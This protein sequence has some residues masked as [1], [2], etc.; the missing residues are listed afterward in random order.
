MQ[1]TRDLLTTPRRPLDIE[2]YIDIVRR[3]K[4]WLIGPTFAALVISVVLAFLW[5]DSYI[6]LAT[7]QVVPPQVPDR[8]VPT[9]VNLEMSQRINTMAGQILN[10]DTLTNI[11][12][13]YGLYKKEISRR[14]MEDVIEDMRNKYVKISPVLRVHGTGAR[15]GSVSA[16]SIA[17]EYENRVL[18]QK[19]TQDLAGRFID[20]NIRSRSSQSVMTTEFLKDQLEAAKK[21]LDALENK[22]TEFRLRNA[23]RLP[24]QLQSNLQAIHTF[25][26]Q[27]AGVNEVIS[28]IGQE[29]LLLES[30]VR[31]LKDQLNSLSTG[32]DAVTSAVKSERLAQVEGEI[33]RLETALTGL[34]ERYSDS[35]PDVKQLKTQ[36]SA[37]QKTR[38][39]LLN[40]EPENK[41]A[42]AP[43]RSPNTMQA[44]STQELEAS[45]ARLQ[46]QIE[47]KDLELEQRTKE[48]EQLKQTLR[49]YNSRIEARPIME[50]EYAELTR[51]YGLAKA[52]YDE[53]NKKTSV[54]E[55]AT[56]LENRRQGERL[57]LL[58]GASLP[59]TPAK[60]NRLLITGFGLGLGLMLGV[61]TTGAR[62]MKDTSLKNLKDARAY[63]NVP[64]LGTIPLL[65]NDL[66]VRR[67]RRLAWLAWSAASI[68]GIL[69]MTSSIYYYYATRV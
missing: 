55:M 53:L 11:I 21:E 41:P 3:H 42:P 24:E 22:L 61:F 51:N 39:G 63:T 13:T 62:E 46:S 66:V 33:L 67:K 27:L 20:E 52:R 31:I 14:P 32:G 50:Q 19:V 5:P 37:V 43:A 49:T 57:E 65:E 56:D 36:L 69:A 4:D 29:K 9:N 45:I 26:T 48:Q 40:Q 30:Q 18:A 23:G 6:S 38:D 2:D 35:H 44:R 34:R 1:P 15:S 28:R 8:F 68:A 25:E 54:S 17:F 59:E 60:P 58:E 47:A 10:R 7:I 12:Q 64:V 16:F